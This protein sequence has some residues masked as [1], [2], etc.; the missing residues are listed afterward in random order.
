MA[1]IVRTV[2]IDAPVEE[3]F[4]YVED[5]ANVPEYWPSVIEVKDVDSLPGGGFKYR[6]VYKMAG[7][8][9]EGGTE[10]TEFL[11]NHRTVSENS[12]GV[13]GAVT[14]TYQ[15][16]AGKTHVTFEAEYHV[17]I[18]LLRNLAESFLLKL[19]EQEAKALLAN[20]KA[21]MEA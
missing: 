5:P 11:L 8:R 10:T 2:T 1:T 21:K 15:A 18:P 13:S 14:W 19:N 16:E 12:G 3:V 9:F 6:W 4:S 20:V 7:V 17:N